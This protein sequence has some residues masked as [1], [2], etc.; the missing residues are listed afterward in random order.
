MDPQLTTLNIPTRP[1]SETWLRDQN[2]ADVTRCAVPSVWST[3]EGDRFEGFSE[4]EERTEE[5]GAED[6]EGT[7][8]GEEGRRED[9]RNRRVTAE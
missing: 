5:A 4:T 8:L 3:T 1:D 7:P 2:V 9:P 6:L